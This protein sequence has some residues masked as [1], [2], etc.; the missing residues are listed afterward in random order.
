[1]DGITRVGKYADDTA[2]RVF[3]IRTSADAYPSG[4]VY[5]LHYGATRPNPQTR[6]TTI[7]FPGMVE[8]RDRFWSEIPNEA[9]ETD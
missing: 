8:L 2:V 4:W 3:V 1:M 9:F 6:S 7:E 5:K